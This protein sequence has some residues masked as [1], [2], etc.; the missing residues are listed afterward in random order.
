MEEKRVVRTEMARVWT[1]VIIRV[2]L[3]MA[4]F[5]I[6]AWLIYMLSGLILLLIIA[7]FFCYLI[8]PIVRA[9]EQPLY[10]SGRELRIPRPFAIL[11]VYALMGT[12][13]YVGGRIIVNAVIGQVNH[14]A[15]QMTDP[16]SQLRGQ[17]GNVVSWV[18]RA[19]ESLKG[20][21][22]AESYE[23]LNQRINE[24][25]QMAI[26]VLQT[27]VE[28][29]PGFLFSLVYLILVPI[30]AFF[31]LKDAGKIEAGLVSFMPTERLQKRVR[32]LLL[33]VSRTLAAY[34]R[35]QITACLEVGVLVTLGLYILRVDY[36]IVIGVV[37]GLFEFFPM[38]GPVIAGATAFALA[39]VTGGINKALAVALFLVI[40]RLVQDYIIYPRIVGHGIEMHP[41]VVILS[42]IGGE[43]VYGLIGV[44]LSIPIVA[45]MMVVY[46]H[47]IAYRGVQGARAAEVAEQ[48]ESPPGDAQ[49]APSAG[50]APA[51]EK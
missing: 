34:I 40:L 8:A 9:F 50:A 5:A 22:P 4:G 12:M 48:S 29:V 21:L 10:V 32:W 1:S 35:A 46:S 42:V 15:A 17:V 36:A 16:N 31:L 51:L 41:L 49:L 33:D 13:V 39:L 24:L 20:T 19:S 27:I 44:F 6:A 2:L 26:S 37:A 7:I 11:I 3:I 43:Q 25:P 28:A 14:L 23:K 18:E 47:Y 45:M 38:I 30:F